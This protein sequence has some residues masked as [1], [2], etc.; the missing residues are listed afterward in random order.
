MSAPGNATGNATGRRDVDFEA[1]RKRFPVLDE[2]TFLACQCMGPFPRETLDDL[3]AYRRS[4]FLRNRVIDEWVE[5]LDALRGQ[6][7][8]LLNAPAGSVMLRDS[9]TAAQA[10]V[11]AALAPEPARNRVVLSTGDFHSSRFL[12]LAQEA[13]GF[14]PVQVDAHGVGGGDEAFLDAIDERTAV[15]ALSLVSP[16]TGALLDVAPVVARAREVGALVIVDAYQAVGIVPIDVRAMGADMVVGGTHKWLGGGGMG[17]AFAYLEPTLSERLRPVYPGWIGNAQ[18]LGF[19]EKFEPAPGALRFQQGTPAME[20]VY[21]ARGGTSWVLEMGT[22]A[23]RARSLLLTG[24]LLA[25]ARDL[26]LKLRTPLEPERR[27]GMVCLDIPDAGRV[28]DALETQGI[29]LDSRPNAGLRMGPHPCVTE[30]ECDRVIAAV[31]RALH[32]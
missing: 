15:V 27:G 24:R 5:R 11:A 19:G 12:W 29:D 16:R 9:A 26:G 23:L 14:A 17:L 7:E 31:A 22:S 2:R 28:V 13:R 18:L 3:D 25:G 10:A 20:P 30:E 1:E 21:T 4:L 8:Q 32:L 6:F